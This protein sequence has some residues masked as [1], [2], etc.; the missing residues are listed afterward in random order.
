M[1]AGAGGDDDYGAVEDDYGNDE[2]GGD[3]LAGFNLSA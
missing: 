1:A 2:A 3:P